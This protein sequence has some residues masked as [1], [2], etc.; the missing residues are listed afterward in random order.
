M[1][2][3]R[4]YRFYVPCYRVVLGA[5]VESCMAIMW[6]RTLR[7]CRVVNRANMSSSMASMRRRR[8][9][10]FVVSPGAVRFHAF[11]ASWW[12]VAR[13]VENVLGGPLGVVGWPLLSL[14]FPR[15]CGKLMRQDF[16]KPEC[17]NASVQSCV[18]PHVV[19]RQC[20]DGSFWGRAVCYGPEGPFH[21]REPIRK[22][23]THS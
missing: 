17:R 2:G 6:S 15:T 19:S 3:S 10:L 11:G 23:R 14:G 8:W 1:F 22:K 5:Y 21:K 4:F 9:F 16:M 20:F 12:A 18:A 13:R 7:P